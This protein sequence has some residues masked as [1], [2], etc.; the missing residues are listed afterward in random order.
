M[1]K[2]LKRVICS[3]LVMIT[4]IGYVVPLLPEGLF[5][6][7]AAEDDFEALYV[8]S[9]RLKDFKVSTLKYSAIDE[10]EFYDDE[11]ET[12]KAIL[13]E[14]ANTNPQSQFTRLMESVPIKGDKNGFNFNSYTLNSA[15]MS[16]LNMYT[17]RGK[18]PYNSYNDALSDLPT[19]LKT[20]DYGHFVK[21]LN[22]VY[23]VQ[24]H[25]EAYSEAEKQ[26]YY[27]FGYFVDN[28][29]IWTT[30]WDT[31]SY[32]ILR[33]DQILNIAFKVY[34][35]DFGGSQA[36]YWNEE[37]PSDNSVVGEYIYQGKSA[38]KLEDMISCF[39]IDDKV[40][41]IADGVKQGVYVRGSVPELTIFECFTGITGAHV[42]SGESPRWDVIFAPKN[43]LIYEMNY[44]NGNEN[45]NI[46]LSN[47]S[48]YRARFS[49]ATDEYKFKLSSEFL[50]FGDTGEF[51]SSKTIAGTDY[52][53]SVQK[54]IGQL[55]LLIQ[56]ITQVDITDNDE[57]YKKA[58]AYVGKIEYDANGE[59][60]KRY[61]ADGV[62]LFNDD[63]ES[64]P[65]SIITVHRD[66]VLDILPIFLKEMKE[67]Q[68]LWVMDGA[69]AD[70]T[71][72]AFNELRESDKFEIVSKILSMNILNTANEE[73][74]QTTKE[75]TFDNG[76]KR[77]RL[78]WSDT[79]PGTAHYTIKTLFDSLPLY[80]QTILS[81]SYDTIYDLRFAD[82]FASNKISGLDFDSE[83]GVSPNLVYSPDIAVRLREK[84]QLSIES[85]KSTIESRDQSIINT[86]SVYNVARNANSLGQY[87]IGIGLYSEGDSD[88][89]GLYSIYDAT[90]QSLCH[91]NYEWNGINEEWFP[92]Y[93]PRDLGFLTETIQVNNVSMP[94][95]TVLKADNVEDLEVF[96][97]FLYN[98]TYAFE[99]SAFS[100]GAASSG[101]TY[102][103]ISELLKTGNTENSQL[104]NEL[105]WISES[106]NLQA[107]GSAGASTAKSLPLQGSDFSIGMIRSIIELHDF[108]EFLEILNSD[109]ELT[110][111]W[112]DAIKEYLNL[113][114]DY[115]DI[116][117][118]FRQNPDIYNLAPQ[119][120]STPEEPLG[121]FFNIANKQLTDNWIKG[122]SL[123]SQYVPME[124]NLYDATSVEMIKDSDWISD[125][126]YKY[127]FYRKALYIN[128]D[129]SA[130]V[131]AFISQ[132]QSTTRVA[133]LRDLLNYDRDIILTIDDN[134]YNADDISD[135]IS[136]LDYASVRQN[137]DATAQ[138]DG[139]QLYKM[140]D[141][142]SG[143]FSLAPG[144]ILKTGQKMYYSDTL[145]QI[146]TK[147]NKSD[148]ATATILQKAFDTYLLPQ[149]EIL[150]D[151]AALNDYEYSVKQS[152]AVVS[153]I[154]RS[155][156]LYNETLKAIVSDNAIFKSSK[157]ICYTPGTSS[158]DWRAI[159]NYYMLANLSD[160][161]KND[162]ASTLDLDAPIFCDIFGNIVTESGLVIIPAASNPTLCGKDWNPYTV[163]FAEYYNNGE[164]IKTGEFA[165][166]V[167]TWLLG[168]EYSTVPKGPD[169][170]PVLT[171]TERVK[172]N[173]GGHFEIDRGG[174]LIL[175]TTSLSSNNLTAIIQWNALNKNSTIIK[176][177]FFNDAYFNKGKNMYHNRIVN[178]IVETLRGA[179]I[180][181]IDYT[182]EGLDGNM[183]ISKYGIYMAYKL[184]E[185]TNSLISGTN[186]NATGGNAA[187][188]M[189]N[190]AFVS[191]IEYIVLYVFK[192]VFAVAVAGLAVSLYLD[193]VVNSL[194]IRSVGKFIITVSMVIVAITLVPNLISWSYYKANKD[195]LS[196]EVGY[197]MMLNYC[198]EFDGSEIG[199][200]SVN[201]PE[202]NTELF[203]KVDDISVDWWDIID[204]VLFKNTFKTVTE[205]YESQKEGNAMQ[206][207]PGVITKGDGL[208][209]NVQDIY[210]ST[211]MN[212][213][214]A[215]GVIKNTVY[216][217]GSSDNSVD[218]VTSFTLPYYTILEQ[219]IANVNEYNITRDITAYSYSVGAN[220]SILTYDI[221]GPYLRSDEFLLDGYDILGLD[222]ILNLKNQR[223]CY[224][225]AFTDSDINKMKL[226]QWYPTDMYTQDMKASAVDRLYEAARVYVADN[227]ELI[228]KVPDEVF[229]KVMAM[230]MAIEFNREFG[231][232]YGRSIEIMN[233]DTRDLA[234]FMVSDRASMYKYFSYGYARY[235]YEEAGGIGV[236]FAA[237]FTVILYLTA[238]VK[239]VFMV[240]ILWLLIFNTIFRKLL[241][242]KESKSIE[243]YLI[244]CACLCLV[245][246][247]YSAML[248]VSLNIANTELGSITALACAIIVQL[249]YIFGLCLVLRIEIKDWK[250][251]G[252][253]EFKNVGANILAGVTHARQVV[254]ERLIAKNNESYASSAPSRRFT[255]GDVDM[256]TI[257]DMIDRDQEREEKGTY[258]PA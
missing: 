113:Y 23:I 207:L 243:G 69:G 96:L 4:V 185:L 169:E 177:L 157:A 198:K 134:F 257:D 82:K 38:Y 119:G 179:P 8:Y 162:A 120:E 211:N 245:N 156:S 254:V 246:Y 107:W 190:L 253:G 34:D 146:C 35:D 101:Y 52:P 229:L 18:L 99:V 63:T 129:N 165:D 16:T 102:D 15:N 75:I 200:T 227:A 68:A 9:A 251:S 135:V 174:D 252:Y 182:Y 21:D 29:N 197:I 160:Q 66:S 97:M 152:Y 32:G 147:L 151:D 74:F 104:K 168:Y 154:Y 241:F 239:P 87:I 123:S 180:E 155:E 59:V 13:S 90:L 236:I 144:Q 1:S 127:A 249:L 192:I 213:L 161:M 256:G 145:A 100:E 116:F 247:A 225:F 143:A 228:G 121:N 158:A 60:S 57:W 19:D 193:A 195:L 230:Q 159:Y 181:S 139:S 5:E 26:F 24:V 3:L 183:D 221:I 240:I 58:T 78:C 164:H 71:I 124:T 137:T 12:S 67:R 187:V 172:K 210:G 212:Y 79:P 204:D 203:L 112:T 131:N 220:G 54:F 258:S 110:I 138:E 85:L 232:P 115:K 136:K 84:P 132:T 244:G 39:N 222:K 173:G 255:S 176:Q 56:A 242:R 122:F 250:N 128:T 194:G 76:T 234:R 80:Q 98:L 91:L 167:Y 166:E 7:N 20:I 224:N 10:Y 36:Q 55:G 219:L 64:L 218:T 37:T 14:V 126:Y 25:L 105:N 51:D 186:G 28:Q 199:I 117:E 133:T 237:I 233:I 33:S 111:V 178:M 118:A 148:D 27:F 44:K 150:G 248:K 70:L 89:Q 94:L 50:D 43:C 209:V 40:D 22:E 17:E 130:I 114:K 153:A 141:W 77:V 170:D 46:S 235:V 92:E 93:L 6:V 140:T 49:D 205:L 201:T 108:C 175:R 196:D 11:D 72:E 231:A 184:E 142:V 215:T 214:P 61:F 106:N 41:I 216:G 171:S 53:K 109:G 81:Y 47:K 208:Y 95:L 48:E 163:G 217:S 83:T 202:T 188:T 31:F 86:R 42:K 2:R 238:F 125:F 62:T 88:G 206:G 103:K 30:N 73:T 189:P 226:S 149:D 223:L 45:F 191:G 65:N